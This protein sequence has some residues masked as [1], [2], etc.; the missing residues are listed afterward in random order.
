MRVGKL[1]LPYSLRRAQEAPVFE[2]QGLSN[3]GFC[4]IPPFELH[5]ICIGILVGKQPEGE[6]SGEAPAQIVMQIPRS[7]NGGIY[8]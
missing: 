8:R 7:S 1:F 5:G 6:I 2:A 3:P 4:K